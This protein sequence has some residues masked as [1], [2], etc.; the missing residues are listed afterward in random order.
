MKAE[1]I[2]DILAQ[3][4]ENGCWNALQSG[5]RY[6]PAF[7][8]YCPNYKSTL[9]TMLLLAD[10]GTPP[11]TGGLEEPF[12]IMAERFFDADAGIY[13]IGKSHFPI[14]CLNGNMIYLHSYFGFEDQTRVDSIVDFFHRWQRFDDGGYKTPNDYPYF[15]NRSCYGSHTC[16]WGVVKLFKG[17]SFIPESKRS[18]KT[19]EL[20]SR[21]I[22]FILLHEVCFSSKSREDFIHPM[23][24]KLCFPQMYKSDYLEI[25]WLMK[26][27]G[28]RDDGLK[29]AV[30]LLLSK[31]DS[32]GSW[33]PERKVGKLS[34]PLGA[35]QAEVFLRERAEE[36]VDFYQCL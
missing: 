24:G 26:R 12:R 15:R 8:Y 34:V 30:N 6:Y 29:R 1:L 36:V 17:L 5:D 21:C 16:Y 35:K 3:Q 14:P 25:L 27:E 2:A 22:N 23:I 9:W 31:R 33:K 10:I 11:E 18:D 4:D 13:T 19:R 28:V 32:G 20:I 7:Q